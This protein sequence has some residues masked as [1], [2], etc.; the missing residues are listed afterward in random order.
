MSDNV[1]QPLDLVAERAQLGSALE[2]AVLSVLH[3]GQYVLGPEVERFE[4]DFAALHGAEHG[5]GVASGTDA[6]ILALRGLGVGPGDRVLTSP[7]TFFASAG[8]IAWVGA[9]P[10]FCDVDPETA[11]IDPETAEKALGPGVKGILPVHLYGQLVDVTGFR[12][13]CDDKG[14]FLLEDAAQA[15]AAVRGGKRAGEVGDVATFSFYP[16][17]NLGAAGEGGALVTRNG[18]LA[19]RLR[20]LRDHGS[21]AKYSH[22]FVGTN[23]RLAALQA[24]VLNVKL[25]HLAA[26]TDRRRAIAGHYDEA[27]GGG[28][29]V[30][31]LRCAADSE[32]VY[33]Q[34]TV[35]VRTGTRDAFLEHLGERGVRAAVHYPSPVH[36]QAAAREWGVGPGDFPHAEALAREVVCLPVHPFL[37]DG[38]A[39]RVAAAATA[40]AG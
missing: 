34:Y 5:I 27:L 10:V 4:R 15:H 29:H 38:D 28:S 21:P 14:L 26:W 1:I 30:T 36:H 12:Q 13:L 3:S 39:E 31:P 40:W 18:D 11:L 6:L 2:D 16:T 35:R 33:H 25:P 9:Q 23:S 7:F 22:A 19:K 24:A 32:P 8:A 20:E 17:K 37:S